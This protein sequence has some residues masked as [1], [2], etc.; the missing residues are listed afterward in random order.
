MK[1][2]IIFSIA[3]LALLACK[4]EQNVDGNPELTVDKEAVYFAADGG[5]E[6]LNVKSNCYWDIS[7]ADANGKIITWAQV[8]TAKGQGDLALEITASS[9]IRTEVREA[10]LTISTPSSEKLTKTV[11][12]SQEKGDKPQTSGYDFPVCE[13]LEIDDSESRQ[14]TNAAI[15]GNMVEFRGGMVLTRTNEEGTFIFDCP[16]H[17]QPSTGTDADRSIHRSLKMDGFAQNES[18]IIEIPVKDELSGDL[19]LMLGARAAS[20]TKEGWSYYWSN[21]AESWNKLTIAN[22]I[23]PGSDAVW[24]VIPFSIPAVDKVPAGGKLY[25]KITADNKPSKDYVSISNTIAVLPAHAAK[26]TLPAMDNNKQAY[27]NCFDD[28]I[29]SPAAYME[30]KLGW[31]RSA[32]TGYASNF[33]SFGD[34]YILPEEQAGIAAVQGCYERPGY[35]QVG[36]Y[37]ESLWTRMCCGKFTVKIGERLKQMG[38]SLTD[39]DV[40]LDASVMKDFRGYESVANIQVISGTDTTTLT[41]VLNSEFKE[42]TVSFTDLNQESEIVITCPRLTDDQVAALVRGENAKYLQDYRFFIDNLQVVLTN[43][44]ERGSETGGDNENLTDG[45]KYNW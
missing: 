12:I 2:V 22:A 27:T 1:K 7:L 5:T 11:L 15:G 6:V 32:T 41:G 28:L 36:Y 25:M 4:K 38:V 23:T 21:D 31:M 29:D 34:Q 8:S 43:I 3:C 24:N 39:A 10:Y 20:F 16:S 33:T 13:T 40:K 44:K 37:D 19:R 45:N 26:G 14:L 42:F 17:T 30:Y 35:L 9:N 18:L